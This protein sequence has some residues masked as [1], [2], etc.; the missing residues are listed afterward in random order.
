MLSSDIS[1]NNINFFEE[2]IKSVSWQIK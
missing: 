1:K 2:I